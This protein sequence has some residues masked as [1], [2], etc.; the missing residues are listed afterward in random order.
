MAVTF[1]HS[2]EPTEDDSS[3]DAT[4][5][6]EP[7][8]GSS[9]V[10]VNT[11]FQPETQTHQKTS[12][13]PKSI[14]YAAAAT[15]VAL[16]CARYA[17]K[18]QS[19]EVYSTP[20][21]YVEKGSLNIVWPESIDTRPVIMDEILNYSNRATDNSEILY[22][23]SP[24]LIERS[25]KNFF[26][27][28]LTIPEGALSESDQ[29]NLAEDIDWA[30]LHCYMKLNNSTKFLL[31]NTDLQ[32]KYEIA[33]D[34]ASRN[35]R[36]QIKKVQDEYKKEGYVGVRTEG[37]QMWWIQEGNKLNRNEVIW[38]I[39]ETFIAT[40]EHIERIKD[41]SPGKTDAV[42]AS[43]YG[44][45]QNLSY[46]DYLTTLKAGSDPAFTEDEF[47]HLRGIFYPAK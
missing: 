29:V 11:S 15:I 47:N 45:A 40:V 27:Y 8:Q 36:F 10:E 32:V 24:D 44:A 4:N 34:L 38:G 26:S 7:L 28:G 35:Q 30:L 17:E 18:P 23:T 3:L 37:L 14:G 31:T 21:P 1:E 19:P 13:L 46:D 2:F 22:V 39:L 33:E 5:F 42:K 43:I 16:V 9:E 41:Y 25:A 20:N 12:I 6:N